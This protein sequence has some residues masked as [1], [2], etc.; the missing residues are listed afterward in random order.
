MKD[1]LK[2]LLLIAAAIGKDTSLVQAGY[3]NVSVKCSGGKVLFTKAR[4]FALKQM[5]RDHG[6][7]EVSMDDAMDVY[8]RNDIRALPR[9]RRE[10]AVQELL[11]GSIPDFSRGHPAMEIPMHLL[12]DRLV[13]YTNPIPVISV[14]CHPEGEQIIKELNSR[15]EQKPILWV[16]YAAP[17]TPLIYSFEEHVHQYLR[18]HGFNPSVIILQHHGLLCSGKD[19]DESLGLLNRLVETLSEYFGPVH[20]IDQQPPLDEATQK[21]VSSAV[22]KAGHRTRVGPMLI[23]FSEEAELLYA[24]RNKSQ[25][26][27]ASAL[28]PAHIIHNGPGAVFVGREDGEEK[29]TGELTDFHRQYGMFPR[30]II[31]EGRGTCILG[32]TTQE[33][34]SGEQLALAAVQAVLLA[35]IP[36]EGIAPREVE[37]IINWQAE[38]HRVRQVASQE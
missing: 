28:S 26:V 19:T 7:I 36:L 8:N 21:M 32:E 4:E 38:Q 3:G 24:P 33:L 25:Q 27:F 22:R 5:D 15:G 37:Y 35:K 13:I 23:R 17:G 29:I 30:V 34:D 16:P 1:E 18:D 11:D 10:K 9:S 14:S 6:W 31:L 20:P 12:L 2:E